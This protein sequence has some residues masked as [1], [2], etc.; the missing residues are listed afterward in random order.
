[1]KIPFA[2][3]GAVHRELNGEISKAI[4][5]VI[6]RGDFILGKDVLEFEN[7]FSKECGCQFGVGVN[8]GTDALFLSILSLGIGPQ[9]EV[10]VP[11][12]TYIAT[13]LAV[14]Y[15]GARPVFVDIDEETYNIDP[16]KIQKAITKK[17]KAIIPV[18]LFGQPANMPQILRIAKDKGLKVIE[19]VAQAHGATIKLGQKGW[20][21]VGSLG[22]TGCFSFYPSKNLGAM[23]DAGMVV[24]NDEQIYQ[25]LL[26]LRDQGRITKYKHT[27]I[28]YNARLDTLQAAILRVKLRRLNQWNSMR[29]KAART[30][31]K[32]LK[33][34]KGVAIPKVA[35]G[36]RHVYHIYAI[37]VK[38]RD[39]V[40]E[41][42]RE[43]GITAMLH[44]PIPL[45][46][47]MA[48][49][50]LGYRK[51]DFPVSEKIASEII[52]LPMHPYLRENQIKYIAKDLKG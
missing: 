12:F 6:S 22:D 23:G 38:N 14:S 13:A 44:Y 3:L 4:R 19:D 24:T 34:I 39:K 1:M 49:R 11:D 33:G 48:Y 42:L 43:K 15:T 51:G 36:L 18:H 25:K 27:I 47:Q 32:Y 31:D 5:E 35:A 46:L 16:R 7:E 41:H 50:H 26:I 20:K 29:Q 45:H 9:D 52:S 37:R 21:K 2:D 10:I 40:Y 17:T 8:S 30:Y 28:G